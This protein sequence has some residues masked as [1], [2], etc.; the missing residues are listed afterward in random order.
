MKR[1]HEIA[2]FLAENPLMEQNMVTL[3][4]IEL[5]HVRGSTLA[6]PTSKRSSRATE[7]HVRGT[8]T[9][10]SAHGHIAS[11]AQSLVQRTQ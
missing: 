1:A 2:C 10:S 11:T 6:P 7:A 4:A 3:K 9:T 5:V 8:Q